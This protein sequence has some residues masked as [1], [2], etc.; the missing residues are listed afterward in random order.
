MLCHPAQVAKNFR[1]CA[2][3]CVFCNVI[4]REKPQSK[5]SER[6]LLT[7]VLIFIVHYTATNKGREWMDM[8]SNISIK[9]C[10]CHEHAI[11]ALELW[12][13]LHVSTHPVLLRF[14]GVVRHVNEA[15]HADQLDHF[16]V[17]P[18]WS[19]PL[20]DPALNM[21]MHRVHDALAIP[22]SPVPQGM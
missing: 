17:I 6:M 14:L 9:S 5:R 16:L 3:N 22:N 20:Q 2:T 8:V 15:C 19:S 10:F 7:R 1:C 12:I 13:H 11:E 21:H 4:G 18:T